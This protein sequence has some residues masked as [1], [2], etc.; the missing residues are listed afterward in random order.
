MDI[1]IKYGLGEIFIYKPI[2]NRFYNELNDR[3]L[4][5][6]L[7][8]LDYLYFK[9]IM[10][11]TYHKNSPQEITL[12]IIDQLIDNAPETIVIEFG[13]TNQYFPNTNTV[14]FN[15]LNGV[16][17]R[18]NFKERFFGSNIGLNSPVSLLAHELV[19]CYH[20][21]FDE[22]GY[23]NRKSDQSMLGEKLADNGKDLSF[24]NQEEVLVVTL[25][26]QICERLGEDKRGNYGRNYYLTKN[27]LTTDKIPT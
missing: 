16:M 2:Q 7:T 20:E 18:K 3:F 26:N 11:V 15:D 12:D 17:F 6:T 13:E 27:V 19:H 25:T 10:R 1:Q 14:K 24:P 21:L 9:D 4:R 23:K 22:N 5:N 8:A